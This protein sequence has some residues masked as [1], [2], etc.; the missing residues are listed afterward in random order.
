MQLCV[1]DETATGQSLYELSLEFLTERITVRDLI[2]ERVSHE[3]REFNRRQGELTFRG[4]VQ[5]T[6]TEQILNGAGV[7]F[8]LKRHRPIDWEVQFERAMVGFANN[9]FFVLIDHQ[10]ADSLDQ[11]FMIGPTTRVSF[12]RLIPLVG[13]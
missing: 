11:E 6:D 5:P 8:R 13:G 3:V 4:L 1:R 10:Q 9:G 12:V 2:R 7:A